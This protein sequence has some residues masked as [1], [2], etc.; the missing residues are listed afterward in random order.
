MTPSI[1]GWQKKRGGNSIDS[2]LIKSLI[3]ICPISIQNNAFI[4]LRS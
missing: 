3:E 4:L 1:G 2:L